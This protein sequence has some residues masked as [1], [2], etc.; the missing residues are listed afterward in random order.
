MVFRRCS[1]RRVLYGY[2]LHL[3]TLTNRRLFVLHLGQSA[4]R[5]DRVEAIL[6]G[7][8]SGT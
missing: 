3:L 2:L 1:G 7:Q 8:V 4:R 5:M 6:R